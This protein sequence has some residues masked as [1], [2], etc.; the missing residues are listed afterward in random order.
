MSG[1]VIGA[2]RPAGAAAVG[3]GKS[4]VAAVAAVKGGLWAV[5]ASSAMA[6]G[7]AGMALVLG[8]ICVPLLLNPDAREQA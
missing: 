7:G 1:Q 3:P 5:L 6:R 4:P 8:P 2:T